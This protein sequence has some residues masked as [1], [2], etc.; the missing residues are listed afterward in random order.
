MPHKLLDPDIKSAKPKDKPYNL[1]DGYGLVLQ[2]Q[3]TG[4]K[5]W[6]YR[7]RY[8]G[9]AKMLS[10]GIYPAVSLKE[11]REKRTEA[12]KL[13]AQGIDPSADRDAK[14]RQKIQEYAH[15]FE[16]VA[17][18]W[19]EEK[20]KSL[21]E[22]HA[23]Y[24]IRRLECDV[25]PEIGKIPVTQITAKLISRVV[26]KKEK[27]GAAEMARRIL[28]YCGQVMRYAVLHDMAETNPVKDIKAGEVLT[29]PP[30][31]NYA[32]V[33]EK[34]FPALLRD[35]DAYS[36]AVLTRHAMQLMTL[37]FVRT[38]EL[39]GARWAE[40][41][42]D[43]KQ[44]RIPAERMKMG[45]QHIVPLSNQALAVLANIRAISG[46]EFLFPSV[47]RGGKTMS[48][49]TM[50]TALKRMGYQGRMT[51]HGFRGIASTILH[52]QNFN[53]DHIE[54]QLAH[55]KRTSVSA[56]YN[57]AKYLPQRTAMMQHWADYLDAIKTGGKVLSLRGA[58]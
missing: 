17:R 27:T 49:N 18:Q 31:T 26:K 11:A 3:P 44:W 16:V 37:T 7:Y 22:R 43:A 23:G 42:L 10:L 52:E 30:V 5:W 58:A 8:L 28:Q 9:K 2:V 34:E 57:H 33:D 14:K 40:F 12:A 51:G 55:G 21:S 45:E 29:K 56:A 36:G 53:H 13:L 15:S 48:N 20:Q 1:A 54:T 41:D 46:G 39:I 47:H 19:W 25:F 6:R 50:L 35:I 38:A 32:R 24:V 4:A